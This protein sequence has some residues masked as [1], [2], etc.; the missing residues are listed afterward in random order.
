[1][2]EILRPRSL[3]EL[4]S[5][6]FDLVFGNLPALI[7]IQAIFW[8]PVSVL[9]YLVAS[10]MKDV[11]IR[12]DSSGGVVLDQ[13]LLIGVV[14]LVFSFVAVLIIQPIMSAASMLVISDSFMGRKTSVG[15]AI[16]LALRRFGSLIMVGFVITLCAFVCALI[17]FVGLG[18]ST[19]LGGLGMIVGL[20][21][22]IACIVLSIRIQIMF[23]VAAPAVALENLGTGAALQRSR[24]LTAGHRMKIFFLMFNLVPYIALRI[25]S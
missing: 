21:F 6:T 18:A 12:V 11:S 8:L 24:Y 17:G 1:M 3:G 14:N 7:A 22:A 9:K 19:V 2:A 4:F 10:A 23:G 15:T 16:G 13:N 5:Q 20:G 25:I